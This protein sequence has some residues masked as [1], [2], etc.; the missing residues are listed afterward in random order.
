[1]QVRSSPFELC[2]SRNCRP[3]TQC[4]NANLSTSICHDAASLS[5][6]PIHALSAP[7][8]SATY[9]KERMSPGHLTSH[10]LPSHVEIGPKLAAHLIL[11]RW[12]HQTRPRV[13]ARCAFGTTSSHFGHVLNWIWQRA[14]SREH[15]L[16]G[17]KVKSVNLSVLGDTCWSTVNGQ[18]IAGE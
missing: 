16:G 5:A 4:C 8:K 10:I 7:I 13:R 17:T 6:F 14:R 15:D 12:R 11:C 1:M 3:H 2:C 18:R 9:A